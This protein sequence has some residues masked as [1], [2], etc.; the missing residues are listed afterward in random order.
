MVIYEVPKTTNVYNTQ[1]LSLYVQC[2]W[3][4]YE[5]HMVIICTIHVVSMGNSHGYIYNIY[6]SHQWLYN[7][8]CP[9]L[10]AHA[11]GYINLQC[12]WFY[13]HY[14]K[15]IINAILVLIVPIPKLHCLQLFIIIIHCH[16]HWTN[17]AFYLMHADMLQ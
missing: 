10:Y 11:S 13:V 2:P 1:C 14:Q 15:I 6:T 16:C 4:R 7:V 17:Y 9:R 12:P 5:I 3:S 8:Y